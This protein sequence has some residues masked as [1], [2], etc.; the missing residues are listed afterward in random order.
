[1]LIPPSTKELKPANLI[2]LTINDFVDTVDT[3]EVIKAYPGD[4]S[5]CDHSEMMLS[6]LMLE[7][8]KQL[9]SS[10]SGRF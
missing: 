10:P 4:E 2:P 6:F 7:Y 8:S 1:M 5:S 3:Q 9:K